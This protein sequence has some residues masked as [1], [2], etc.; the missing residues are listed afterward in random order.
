MAH[1]INSIFIRPMT[2]VKIYIQKAVQIL[3]ILLVC[4][5]AVNAFINRYRFSNMISIDIMYNNENYIVNHH[6]TSSI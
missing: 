4:Y 5:L 6:R 1:I 3:I 2:V